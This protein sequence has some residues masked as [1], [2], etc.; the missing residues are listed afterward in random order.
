MAHGGKRPGS[1]RKRGGVNQKT[2]EIAERAI[3]Q[4]ITPLEVMLAAMRTHYDAKRFDEAASI[5]KDAAPY[6]HPRLNS[7]QI[8][9]EVET[10]STHVVEFVVTTREQADQAIAALAAASGVPRQ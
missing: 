10:E 5:A 9:A 6:M 1:G 4:G 3:A 7:T 8:K 2:R